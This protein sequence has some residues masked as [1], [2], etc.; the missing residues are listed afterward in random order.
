[1]L[2]HLE[3]VGSP[4]ST[5]PVKMYHYNSRRALALLPY[6]LMPDASP[7]EQGDVRRK[8]K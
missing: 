8:R 4:S 7:V 6:Q 1:M 5:V 2:I 3:R